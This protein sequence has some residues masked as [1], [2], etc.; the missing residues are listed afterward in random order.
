MSDGVIVEIA[1]GTRPPADIARDIVS[2]L[3]RF[4]AG[5]AKGERDAARIRTAAKA[6]ERRGWQKRYP[7]GRRNGSP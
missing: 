2:A 1:V 3:T 4:R 7:E 5:L 6:R